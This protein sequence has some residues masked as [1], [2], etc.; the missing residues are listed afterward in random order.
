MSLESNPPAPEPAALPATVSSEALARLARDGSRTAFGELVRRY[1]GSLL[2]FLRPRA[3]N[4]SDAEE[5]VQEVFLRAWSKLDRYDPSYRFSTWL[6]TVARHLSI[7]RS[8]ARRA[9]PAEHDVALLACE[10]DPSE[11]ASKREL[12]EDLW[13]LADRVLTPDQ[14]QALW[15]RY[16][17][18]LSAEEIGQ[19]MKK[20]AVAVRVL[21]FRARE[22]LARHLEH[23][24]ARADRRAAAVESDSRTW[25]VREARS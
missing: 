4:A 2:R 20:R 21:L 7:S 5:A 10:R 22:G 19:V 14:R 15:L 16:A 17:E 18:D 8:R 23:D 24:A 25:V 13:G 3:P 1:E 12:A 11:A 6:F 9:P